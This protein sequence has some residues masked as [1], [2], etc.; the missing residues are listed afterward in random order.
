[1]TTSSLRVHETLALV[2]LLGMTA[3]ALAGEDEWLRP[4]GPPPQ[5]APRRISGGE[6]VPPLPLPAT[7]LRRSERKRDPKPPT[8]I[9]KVM[10]GEK[11]LFTYENGATAE[12]ADWNQ[13]PGDLQQILR[14]GQGLFGLP[15]ASE[16]LPL[17]EFKG[18]PEA[19][20]VLLFSGSR[21]IRLDVR[22]IEQLRAY[23]LRGGMM[24]F[25][26]I[27]GSPYFYDAA[28]KLTEALL[29]ESRLRTIPAD[30][31]F[32]HMLVDVD[33]VR[34]PR[35]LPSTT[36][37]LE[38]AY[39]GSRIGVL[40]SRYGLGCAWDGHEVPLIKDAV[41]Y[42]V[43]S[44]TRI[45][46]NLVAYAVGYASAGREEARP[47]LFGALDE[48][49]PTDE[50]VFAQI[51]HEGAWNLH[52]G[53]AA[54]LLIQLR[55][56]TSLKVSLKRVSVL[57][58][59]DDLS[60]YSFLYLTGLDEFRW[61][62][63]A[64][65][66]LRAFLKNSGTLLINNGLGLRSSDAIIR[67]ELATL[68]PGSTLQK[69]P[70]THPLYSSVFKIT[71]SRYTPAVIQENPGLTTPLLE[72][73]EVDGELRVVY[74][75]YDIEAAWLGCDYPLARAYESSSGTRLGVNMM[76]YFATH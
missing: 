31:P 46:I 54:A 11:A 35:N 53:A 48:K 4:L 37:F 52:P 57:P 64:R 75:P 12:V 38:G 43:E 74:S 50:F 10:W 18:D 62:E 32:Y 70:L 16:A 44:G 14:K 28:R 29:P 21:T 8:L 30:H 17:S 3:V 23:L 27:A 51:E 63:R 40:V 34:Y 41:F 39:V 45:G 7:P 9:N 5:A 42:D 26:S 22:Q 33:Q 1:M 61:D 72:G 19:V 71:E 20:P 24:V 49:H 25:D 67:R 56:N 68:L 76:M 36:P 6:G 69:I 47:E 15:Y 55:Q 65:A 58:G 59:R 66:A 13:C 60:G 73:I 2:A